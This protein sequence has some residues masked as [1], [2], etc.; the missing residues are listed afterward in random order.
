MSRLLLSYINVKNFLLFAE[1]QE[2]EFIKFYP[3]HSIRSMKEDKLFKIQI[4][5]SSN[6]KVYRMYSCSIFYPT[7]AMTSEERG[8][9]DQPARA[10]GTARQPQGGQSASVL[11]HHLSQT[12]TDIIVYRV[13]LYSH[14]MVFFG[15][16]VYNDQAKGKHHQGI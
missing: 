15:G 14:K 2:E 4:P 13:Q 10:A 8:K 12:R 3:S 6:S 5:A 1:I 9:E 16:V 7:T 11:G